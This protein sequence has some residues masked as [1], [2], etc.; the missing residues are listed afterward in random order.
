MEKPLKEILICD[1]RFTN[2]E[3]VDTATASLVNRKSQ[4]VNRSVLTEPAALEKIGTGAL[5]E[6]SGDGEAKV[7]GRAITVAEILNDDRVVLA[8][9]IRKLTNWPGK[10]APLALWH[11]RIVP[12][13]E[14][15]LAQQ[16]LP[17]VRFV[18]QDFRIM[19]EVSLAEQTMKVPVDAHGVALWRPVEREVLP[20][21]CARCPL[22]E[23]CRRLSAAAG[24][25]SLWQ[26]L[27]LVDAAGGPTRRGQ[28]VSYFHGGDG[29]AVAVALEDVRYPLDELIYDLANLHAGHRF[30]G[31]ENR[32]GGR[33]A[34]VCHQAFALQ[35]IPGYLE[36]GVPPDYGAGAEQIVASVH[37]NPLNKHGWATAFLGAGDID[38][39]IIEWR[40]QLRQI[41]HAPA[42]PWPR[43]LGLRDMAKAILSE[44]E[45]PTL[46]ELPPLELHQTKRAEHRLVLRRH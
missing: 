15:R 34:L 35:T 31:E 40:S 12:L 28:M 19:A 32:W 8:K 26:R 16:H 6:L 46:T 27:N 7:Y 4:I 21:D 43:W 13:V 3:L 23:V 20:E 37:K 22:P 29:L 44:T 42:I 36:N 18:T 11:E 41:T 25:A 1:L 45:S 14:Q 33:L 10:Q 38:R 5:I 30:C 39:I 24:V 17:V 9:W 2:D